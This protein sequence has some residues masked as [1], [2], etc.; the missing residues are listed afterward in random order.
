[1]QKC[2]LMMTHSESMRN[3]LWKAVYD[4][5]CKRLEEIIDNELD[6]NSEDER[7]KRVLSIAIENSATDIIELL[8]DRGV[9]IMKLTL[10]GGLEPV[11]YAAKS[12]QFDTIRLLAS[13]GADL[14]ALSQH[15]KTPLEYAQLSRSFDIVH[16]I[17]QNSDQPE[18]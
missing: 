9:D 14:Y 12:G 16:Y 15:G 18:C 10:D 3:R 4:G 5:D 17:I 7:W 8:V 11:H 2:E 13:K 6:F 1:M